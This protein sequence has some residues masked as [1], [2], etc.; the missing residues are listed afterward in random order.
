MFYPF[1]FTDGKLLSA[2]RAVSPITYADQVKAPVF[3]MLGNGDLRVPHSQ[4]L[5]YFRALK[6]MGK[7]VRVNIYDDCHPLSKTPINVDVAIN[8]ALFFHNILKEGNAP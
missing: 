5:E 7:D 6:A 3:L 8:A 4:G 2:M 1:L